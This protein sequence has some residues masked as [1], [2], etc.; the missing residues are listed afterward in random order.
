MLKRCLKHI[1][2]FF[3]AKIKYRGKC[4]FD[5]SCNIDLNSKFEGS[6][7]IYSNS[8]FNGCLGYGTYLSQNCILC[9]NVGRFTSIAPFVR[10]NR[11]VHPFTFPYATTCPMFFSIQ[12][13]NGKT[14]AKR[15]SFDEYSGIISI[16]NDCWIGENVFLVGGISVGD[17]AV[18]LAGAVVT[19]DVPPYA[20]VGGVP[21]KI[22]DYRYDEE[23][24]KFLL[25]IKW[26][27][28]DVQWLKDNCESLCNID[29]LKNQFKGHTDIK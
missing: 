21:A 13:Q 10:T 6:N 26:W 16:G 24:I 11:G 28:K 14:F 8:I 29:K 27:N 23:T 7:K 9:A 12:K 15:N 5:F 18:V 17:G 22:I 2:K 25:D 20:I 4:Q 3:I 1:V 19:K